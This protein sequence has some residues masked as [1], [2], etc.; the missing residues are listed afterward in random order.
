MLYA[1]E[2][3]WCYV[4]SVIRPLQTYLHQTG[5]KLHLSLVIIG[6][7]LWYLHEYYTLK[8]CCANH[9]RLISSYG[10]SEA[11]IDSSY[12]ESTL[13]SEHLERAVPIGKALNNIQLWVLD[14]F[15]QPQPVGI[16]GQLCIAGAGLARGYLNRPELTAEKFIEVQLFGKRER[17]Y[18]TG[19]IAR[20]HAA[21]QF[22]CVGQ[23]ALN[24]Q[25]QN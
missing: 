17:I 1:A 18:K 16:D 15:Y 8:D 19:D 9:T 21:H 2:P 23:T 6:S 24:C 10:V 22:Y 25:W 4:P 13:L 7:E 12:F 3:N 14:Q 11:T 20:L 5:Q